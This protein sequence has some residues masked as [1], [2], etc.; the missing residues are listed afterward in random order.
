MRELLRH[1][2][3]RA[4]VHAGLRATLGSKAAKRARSDERRMRELIASALSP[5]SNGIDVGSHDGWV[6]AE[7]LRVAPHG[8]HIAYEPLPALCRTL[9]ERHPEADVRCAALSN[10]TG[11]VV[12]SI[13]RIIRNGSLS[14]ESC[15][16]TAGPKTVGMVAATPVISQKS[17]SIL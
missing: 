14:H 10:L 15:R 11:R 12:S 1:L 7:L 2:A 8:H 17:R 3:R 13:S 5:Q 16:A 9:S 6:L 4:G